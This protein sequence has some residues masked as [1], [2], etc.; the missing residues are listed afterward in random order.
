MKKFFLK[1]KCWYYRK[2]YAKY[3]LPTIK[4]KNVELTFVPI[5]THSEKLTKTLAINFPVNLKEKL[6][7]VVT[8]DI[9]ENTRWPKPI[10]EKIV[11]CK[12]L[13]MNDEKLF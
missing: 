2:K 11:D 8:L 1:I 10:A 5:P 7:S 3:L 12:K 6:N 4:P 9:R 13:R